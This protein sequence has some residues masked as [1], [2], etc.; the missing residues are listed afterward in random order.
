VCFVHPKDTGQLAR[1]CKDMPERFQKIH[2]DWA[3]FNQAITRFKNNIMTGRKG[4]YTLS[5]WLG[6]KKPPKEILDACA[7][8]WEEEQ[9]GLYTNECNRCSHLGIWL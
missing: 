8:G 9:G 1:K 5:I 3:K 7:L 4:T 2:E 6:S